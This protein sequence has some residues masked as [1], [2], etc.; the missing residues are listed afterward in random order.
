MQ[1]QDEGLW[2]PVA[3]RSASMQLD[4][5]NYEIYDWE[6]LAIIE[7]LK[8]WQNF[9]EGYPEPFKIIT[10]HSNL[11]FWQTAQDLS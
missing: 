4:E 6:M 1:K 8:D 7:A 10:D 3:F 9:L 11:T 5:C 2:H